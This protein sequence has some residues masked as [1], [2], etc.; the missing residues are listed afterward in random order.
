MDS[1]LAYFSLLGY[2]YTLCR[3]AIDMFRDSDAMLI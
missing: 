2:C 1:D 3:Y